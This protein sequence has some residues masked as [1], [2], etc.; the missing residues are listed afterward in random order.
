MFDGLPSNAAH[1]VLP[2]AK[3]IGNAHERLPPA[4]ADSV[5]MLYGDRAEA[6]QPAPQNPQTYQVIFTESVR[7]LTV[8]APVEFPVFHEVTDV[9][10]QLDL[11]TFRFSV[12]VCKGPVWPC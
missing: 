5:F 4:D 9:R 7:G 11:K 10:A 12:P 3:G 6:F 2:T 1:S 8:G